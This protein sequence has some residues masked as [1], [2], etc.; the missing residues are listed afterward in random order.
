MTYRLL[1]QIGLFLLPIMIA[2]H[3]S[4]LTWYIKPDGKGDAATIQAGIDSAAVGDTVLVASGIYEVRDMWM[5]DGVVLKSEDG[6]FSTRLFP[7]QCTWVDPCAAI[8][9]S[10]LHMLETE[11]NGFWI[12]GFVGDWYGAISLCGCD[13][14][15]LNNILVGNH[16]GVTMTVV[17][18]IRLENNTLSG[19]ILT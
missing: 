1:L 8:H 11:I 14:R 16:F 15:V 10:D 2:H 6:P 12:E 19:W 7:D 4:S 3:A 17:S 9:G 13:I 18:G 5:K